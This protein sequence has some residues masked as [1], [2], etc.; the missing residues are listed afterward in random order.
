MSLS[1]LL[2]CSSFNIII[3]KSLPQEKEKHKHQLWSL[4]LSRMWL[5]I[6]FSSNIVVIGIS[7]I[8]FFICS[9]FL[10]NLHAYTI[11]IFDTSWNAR[12]LTILRDLLK[13]WPSKKLLPPHWIISFVSRTECIYYNRC[14][15]QNNIKKSKKKKVKGKSKIHW[16]SIFITYTSVPNRNTRG[17]LNILTVFMHCEK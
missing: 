2:L 8:I 16:L 7:N 17:N 3:R 5:I 15:V 6:T 14:W 1:N 12:H 13:Y 4:F 9:T 11:S 10:L